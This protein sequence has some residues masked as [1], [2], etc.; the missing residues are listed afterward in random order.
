MPI[1]KTWTIDNL[2]CAACGAKVEDRIA[3]ETGVQ[4][5]HLNFMAK[6]LTVTSKTEQ[7]DLFWQGIEQ[8]ARSQ[9]Q[10]IILRPVQIASTCQNR[11]WKLKGLDCADCAANIEKAVSRLDSVQSANL[12][13]MQMKLSVETQTTVDE[14]FW[15]EVEQ[16][17]KN[18]ETGLEMKVI[19]TNAACPYCGKERCECDS[20]KGK[21][22]LW[23]NISLIQ[24][25]ISLSLFLGG[26]LF[27]DGIPSYLLI[28]SSYLVSGYKVLFKAARNILKGKVFDENFLMAI[29][30]LGAMAIGQFSESAAVMLFYQV[31][32]YFQDAAVNSSRRS[33]ARA[34]DLK[35]EFA[36]VVKGNETIDVAVEE[37]PAGSIIRVK[38]GEKIPLDGIV[39]SGSS[40]LD[41]KAL[42]GESTP[43]FVHPNSLV[44][45][46]SFNE[47]SVLDIQVTKVYA[48][49]TV[50]KIMTLVEG[51]SANKA[52]SEQF[53]TRFARLYT[54]FV[55]IVALLLTVIPSLVFG[56]FSTWL[57][58]SLVFL[59][60]SCPCALVISVPLSFFAGIGRSARMGILVKGGNYLQTLSEIDTM[61][62]DK[63]G[64]LTKGT[65]AL[66]SVKVAEGT[67]WT[68]KQIRGFASALESNSSHPIARAFDLFAEGQHKV[69]S[70]TETPGQGMS[71]FVD[72]HQVLAGSSSFLYQKGIL[73]PL[74]ESEDL[75]HVQIAIDGR[76]AGT[77]E[78]ED[79]TK[80]LAKGNLDRLRKLGIK[81]IVM[82]SGDNEAVALRV[83]SNLGIDEIHGGLLPQQKVEIFQSLKKKGGKVAFVGDGIND[84]PVLA[85]SDVGLAMGGLGSDAAIAAADIVILDDDLAKIGT[86][87]A[88]ARKT[89]RIVKQNITFALVIKAVTLLLGAVGIATMW[90]AVFADVGVAM[91]VILNSLR[92]LAY[93]AYR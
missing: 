93:K 5:A 26:S 55:V 68:E 14:Q 77:A 47:S 10:D 8:T 52:P 78:I 30:S 37:V 2:D 4:E 6:K 42:T 17:A 44:N 87:V 89:S 36:H 70:V 73:A 27:L 24:I 58:R 72:G 25:I 41:T 92:L 11:K 28:L 20:I 29:A 75:T 43:T 51:A 62:F 82:L 46:G 23:F 80:D 21:T 1:T 67:S 79:E 53:I 66:R 16:V 57:Y 31:G 33:I 34:M 60:I 81:H 91:L 65:F 49:S 12:D 86:V 76:Y 71:G 7:D 61:V 64:T 45:S 88:I 19:Q 59:V 15:D 83:G 22:N 63:T 84:A 48:D 50:K 85:L 32:E 40:A 56:N 74:G 13:F 35:S 18:I 9:Q 3:K 90:W 69:S 39:V 38:N 54:P